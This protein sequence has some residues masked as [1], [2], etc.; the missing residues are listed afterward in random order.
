ML[1]IVTY[2]DPLLRQMSEPVEA[3]D[4]TLD[5]LLDQ[6][7]DIMYHDDGVGLAAPQ[8]GISK[9]VIVLDDGNGLI[10]LINPF[11]AGSNNQSEAMEEG[12]LSLPGIRVPVGRPTE[13]VV[14]GVTES[15]KPVRYEADALLARILQ[16]EIDHL[17]GVLI[18]DHLSTI[19]RSL[20]KSKLK[21]LEKGV[22]A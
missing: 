4:E 7:Q 12:C 13:V 14:E 22:P 6:M 2:P 20:I 5:E 8:I 9:R 21:K 18:I 10:N 19:Q 3:F 15:G 16:H 1:S 11:I 17:N